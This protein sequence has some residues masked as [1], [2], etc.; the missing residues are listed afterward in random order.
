MGSALFSFFFKTCT[1]LLFIVMFANIY[2][3]I[4]I[5]SKFKLNGNAILKNELGDLLDLYDVFI[6]DYE[7][8]HDVLKSCKIVKLSLYSCSLYISNHHNVKF[9]NGAISV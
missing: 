9:E 4:K 7:E 6:E 8:S 1:V 3:L 5:C 2:N